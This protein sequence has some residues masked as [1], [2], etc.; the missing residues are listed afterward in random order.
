MKTFK[1]IQRVQPGSELNTKGNQSDEE[2][3]E[4]PLITSPDGPEKDVNDVSWHG[5][6][7]YDSPLAG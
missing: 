2:K 3:I 5:Y 7:E 1:E 4:L 6:R